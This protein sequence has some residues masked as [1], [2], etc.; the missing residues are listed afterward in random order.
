MNISTNGGLIDH[1]LRTFIVAR[2]SP[3]RNEEVRGHT[4]LIEAG[5]LSV[6]VIRRG[7]PYIVRGFAPGTWADYNGSIPSDREVADA[8]AE[9]QRV[10][11]ARRQFEILGSEQGQ[12]LKQ[13][14]D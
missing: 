8:L 9:A 1:P 11:D 6:I 10:S 7:L 2:P 4:I 5:V 14:L 3:H 13:R 12:N